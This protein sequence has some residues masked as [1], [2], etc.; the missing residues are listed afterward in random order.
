MAGS[1][2]DNVRIRGSMLRILGRGSG[3]SGVRKGAWTP[4]L[5]RR[6]AH[7]ELLRSDCSGQWR[8]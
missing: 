1:E 8:A 4:E 3:R 7:G 5:L 6:P 2:G